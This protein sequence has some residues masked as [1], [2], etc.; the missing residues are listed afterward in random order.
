MQGRRLRRAAIAKTSAWALI[1]TFVLQTATAAAQD[2]PEGAAQDAPQDA[3]ELPT[4]EVTAEAPVETITPGTPSAGMGASTDMNE[5]A[6]AFTVTGAQVNQRVFSR[7]GEALEI[8]PGLIATQHS[9]DGK[10]NQWFLRGFNLDHGTDLAIFMDGMPMNMPTHAH[11][12]G[13]ADVNMLIPELISSVNIQK[14]PYF[15]DVGDFASAGSVHINLIDS[16][17]QPTVKATLGSFD[18]L[19]YLGLG[20]FQVGGWKSSLRRRGR[21]L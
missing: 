16:V 7:P 18:Y 1:T 11:G 19:R 12:Q 15:A 4:V 21:R 17:D 9:G 2:A 20:S 14:G 6:S 13:Y 8:V 10:A 5:A 3:I